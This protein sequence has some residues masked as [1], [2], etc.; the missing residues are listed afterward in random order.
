MKKRMLFFAAACL[1]TACTK[2][3]VDF[4][5]FD[6]FKVTSVNNAKVAMPDGTLNPEVQFMDTEEPDTKVAAVSATTLAS[7]ILGTITSNELIQ[8][9]GTYEGRDV[10]GSPITLSGKLI[11]PRGGKIK[12]MIIV[13]HY[14]IGSNSECPSESFPLEAIVAAK[15]YAVVMADY[16]GYG[17][18]V[19]RIHPY[20]HVPSTVNAVIDMALAVKPFLTHIGREPESEE[21]ILMGYSQGGSTT[22]GVLRAIQR[23]YSDVFPVKKVYAGG[24]PYDL[25][26]TFDTSME[27]DQTGIPCAIPMIV[28]GINEGEKL[29]LNY[30]DFF[31]PR[32]LANYGEWINSKKYTVGQINKLL[33]VN[34]LHEL[35]TPAGRDKKSP[36]TAKLYRALM[37][38]S[39]L[40]F[41]PGAPVYLFH[42]MDDKTVPFINA[43][44]AEEYFKGCNITFDFGHYGVHGMAA[45]RFIAT[46]ATQL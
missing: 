36:E 22:M 23:Y 13:S 27:A 28:Q 20:M 34:T 46:V 40:N 38:N 5:D 12:N 37:Y 30:A 8:V 39:V 33:G 31:Q 24:G 15:G 14:T 26:A 9:C 42:S 10:D 17:V 32:L 35:M 19:N 45:V 2:P 7:Q 11:L 3:K 18:T 6:T 43:S 16:I 25:A 4:A 21:V 29:G 44:R 41:V 1:L